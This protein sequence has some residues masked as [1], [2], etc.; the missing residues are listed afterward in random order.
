[1]VPVAAT[2]DVL[3][4][5][6]PPDPEEYLLLVRGDTEAER[7][8]IQDLLPA[9]TSLM[10][11]SYLEE[12]VVRAGGFTSLENA[13]AWAQYLTE[14]EG[15]QAFVVRP[16]APGETP[17]PATPV[18][19]P[20]PPAEEVALTN[21]Q[22]TEPA[23]AEPGGYT[24]QLLGEGYAVLVNYNNNPATAQE[25]QELLGTPVGLAVYRQQPYLLASHSPDAATAAETLQILSGSR[26][27]AFIVDSSDVVLLTPAVVVGAG[28]TAEN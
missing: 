20:T 11:C 4:P 18:A 28:V 22:G 27:T 25:A 17:P 8:R 1:M 14:M 21:P 7:D 15:A 23:A 9:S 2:A 26:L 6:A 5:C 24:P 10:V 3:P 19:P 13:N 16:A 12:T